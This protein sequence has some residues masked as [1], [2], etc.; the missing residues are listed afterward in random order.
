M[1]L[2]MDNTTI[3]L[4]EGLFAVASLVFKD[5]FVLG[6][7]RKTNLNDFGLPGGKIDPGETPEQAII[8]ELKEET[9]ITATK[10]RQVYEDLDRVEDG[11]PRPCRTYLV[12]SWEGEPY[13][14]EKARVEWLKPYILF[15]WT[16]SFNRYNI[17]LFQHLKQ[18]GQ[19]YLWTCKED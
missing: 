16:N 2:E 11:Q 8:R 5:G 7:S 4:S 6:V 15:C 14:V 1:P 13:A 18:T 12:E 19:D 3:D 17:D 9:G 10:I